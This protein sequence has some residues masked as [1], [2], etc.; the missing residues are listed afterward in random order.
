MQCTNTASLPCRLLSLRHQQN[1]TY[2]ATAM[3]NILHA[4]RTPTADTMSFA[5][6]DGDLI[7]LEST[8]EWRIVCRRGTLWL[9]TQGRHGQQGQDIE[10]TRDDYRVIENS[11]KVLIEA[12]G[13]TVLDLIAPLPT[14]IFGKRAK[15]RLVR[16][17]KSNS[18]ALATRIAAHQDRYA[19]RPWQARSRYANW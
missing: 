12:V 6:A 10:I 17:S 14:P 3:K 4:F 5:L 7:S 9:S 11:S 2:A 1:L 15:V 19:T 18:W 13:N 16:T 8:T